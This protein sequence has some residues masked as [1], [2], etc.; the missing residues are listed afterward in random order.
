MAKFDRLDVSLYG[1]QG[2]KI[3]LLTGLPRT[4]DT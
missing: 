2:V 3:Q 4:Y 1:W